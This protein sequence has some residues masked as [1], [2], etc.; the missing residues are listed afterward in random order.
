[1]NRPFVENDEPAV[2]AWY[3]SARAALLWN[4]R[5]EPTTIGVKSANEI[6][7]QGLF[8]IRGCLLETL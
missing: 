8:Y 7:A 5:S 3:P 2:L 1:M 4:V 6:P